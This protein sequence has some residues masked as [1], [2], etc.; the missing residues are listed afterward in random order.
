MKFF[1]I[2]P[3]CGDA[4]QVEADHRLDGTDRKG[5]DTQIKRQAAA[6][7]PNCAGKLAEQELS[8]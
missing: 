2:C 6:H 4:V 8:A 1:A 5:L 3:G 7:R